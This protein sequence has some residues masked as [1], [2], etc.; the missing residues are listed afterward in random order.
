MR[1]SKIVRIC[2]LTG[3]IAVMAFS[4]AD[5]QQSWQQK[6]FFEN[7]ES[8][9]AHFYS[10]GNVSAPSALELIDGK[11]P[12]DTSSFVSAPNSLR[13]SWTSAPA[14]EWDVELRLPNWPNRYLNFTGDTFSLWL[15]SKETMQGSE[16]P[17]ICLHDAGNGFT[18]KVRLGDYAHQLPAGKWTRLLIPMSAFHS[19]SVRPFEPARTN[20]IIFLQG[21]AD[22]HPHTVLLDNVRIE[23]V[24]RHEKTP[25]T[26]TDLHAKSYERHVLLT[27]DA[28]DDPDTA[29][30][31]IYRS[32]N[33]GP[34]VQVQTQRPDIH[35]AVD[36]I[37]QV[38]VTAS[39]RVTARTSGLRE[40][41]PSS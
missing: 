30:Y 14:G 4:S 39:Y 26:P 38:G 3:A 17:L 8:V 37:N 12:V 41:P 9:H 32:M 24:N 34:F 40:S 27:W 23:N 2:M 19:R 31:V 6:E 15:Y 20:T 18:Q 29:E 11:L 13:L 28:S 21:D 7:S 33:G 1:F 25:P 10:E 22:A 5:A 36:F 35:R 16:L